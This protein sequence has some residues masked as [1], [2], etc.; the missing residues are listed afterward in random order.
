MSLTLTRLGNVAALTFLIFPAL[1]FLITIWR[2]GANVPF[3]DDITQILW[4]LN[5]VVEGSLLSTDP[6]QNPGALNALFYPNAGHIPTL[7]RLF[8]LLQYALGGMDFKIAMWVAGACWVATF[9]LLMGAAL[10]TL[11][12]IL[13]M[14][15]AFL[16]FSLNQWE[17]MN[18]M[19]GSWQ[20]Y[21]GTLLLPLAALVAIVHARPLLA[22]TLFAF[23]LFDST[24]ALC[25]LPLASGWYLLHR[26][27]KALL[28]FSLPTLPSLA[29]FLYFNPAS[30]QVASMNADILPR[31]QFA[32][33]FLGNI[34]GNS[35]YDL[36]PLATTHQTIGLFILL[37]GILALRYNRQQ[38]LFKLVFLYVLMLAGLTALKRTE[39]TWV[40]SR[41]SVFALLALCAVYI[42]WM[43]ILKTRFSLVTLGIISFTAT[44]LATGLWFMSYQYGIQPLIQDHATRRAALK[45]YIEQGDTT[46]LMWDA[47]WCHSTLEDAR[48]LGIYDYQQALQGH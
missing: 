22:G 19:L 45:A 17:S 16:A 15:L 47:E 34:Y 4:M 9:F 13:L 6:V 40:V 33:A 20:M 39:Q 23:G 44:A 37:L 36:R 25:V 12:L 21:V 1:V 38:P 32:L 24:G 10:K 7:T 8:G 42:L 26:Q 46:G 27:W 14:P 48:R 18:M 2:Y 28:L 35:S 29:L 43:D 31:L 30:A 3:W 41:Y 5:H 11:P